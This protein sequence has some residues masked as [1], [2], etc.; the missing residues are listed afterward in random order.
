MKMMMIFYKKDW[1]I[2]KRKQQIQKLKEDNKNEQDRFIDSK[3][4]SW[5][6]LDEIN[7]CDSIGN[8]RNCI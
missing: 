4:K 6:F 8:K 7:T 2:K 5:G 3:N 1:K